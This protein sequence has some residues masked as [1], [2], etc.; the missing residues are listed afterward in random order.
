MLLNAITLELCESLRAA[1]KGT[2]FT[3][4]VTEE[5]IRAKS[6]WS[7]NTY[8]AHRPAPPHTSPAEHFMQH[9]K[10]CGETYILVKRPKHHL[11]VVSLS[12]SGHKLRVRYWRAYGWKHHEASRDWRRPNRGPDTEEH[13]KDGK[14]VF[15]LKAIIRGKR[16]RGKWVPAHNK[17]SI[18]D[19]DY[20]RIA[21]EAME[22][23]NASYR[24][25]GL[26]GRRS[27]CEQQLGLLVLAQDGKMFELDPYNCWIV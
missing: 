10:V 7:V 16:E 15:A 3:P 22:V 8:I 21:R 27:K 23:L 17:Y 14:H 19:G 26:Y 9:A 4:L 1:A 11:R 6:G 13:T 18:Q 12:F 5:E 25:A 2:S 24:L 20:C